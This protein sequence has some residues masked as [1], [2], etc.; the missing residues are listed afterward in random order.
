MS[1][2]NEGF[3]WAPMT[4]DLPSLVPRNT[5]PFRS[6]G[7][8]REIPVQDVP[9]QDTLVPDTLD[10]IAKEETKQAFIMSELYP[11]LLFDPL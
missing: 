5:K 2:P 10:K 9:I 7:S 1:T 4:P 3:Q 6:S 11:A 8:P